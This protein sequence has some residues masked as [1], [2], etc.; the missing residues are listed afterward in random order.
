[1]TISTNAYWYDGQIR[2][3]LIQFMAVFAGLQVSIGRNQV[4]STPSLI[5]VPI[6][7]GSP[8]RV[9]ASILADNTQNQPVRLP[10]MS[11]N[12][13][14]IDLAPE[15]A[16]GVA[17]ERRNSYVP[18]G[19]LLPDDVQVVHQ[20][21]PIPYKLTV[22]LG[23]YASNTDQH[24][25]ILEQLLILFDP[26]LTVQTSDGPFD[27]TRLTTVKLN[28][29]TLDQQ[30]PIGTASRVIQSTLTFEMPI[31]IAS[32]ANVRKDFIKTIHMRIGAIDSAITD[33]ED[34]L[35]V[36]DQ[37]GIQYDEIANAADLNVT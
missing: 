27:W 4:T 19:G 13:M 10:I 14:S 17:V 22:Q 6:R 21:M 12:L 33:E 32:P 28:G 5:T 11:A 1:M 3:Y 2:R 16:H 23:I 35:A 26:Q 29:I 34:I 31:Y 24:T 20:R 36:L 25:Q 7:Y 30:Y 9:V 18:T 15:L 8:D 37:M